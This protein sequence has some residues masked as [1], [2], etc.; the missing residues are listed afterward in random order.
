MPGQQH[1]GLGEVEKPAHRMD[2]QS[3]KDMKERIKELEKQLQEKEMMIRSLENSLHISEAKFRGMEEAVKVLGNVIV[4]MS[5]GSQPAGR[6]HSSN[7]PE[8]S[9][10][11]GQTL[12]RATMSTGMVGEG[13]QLA[14]GM[15]YIQQMNQQNPPKVHLHLPEG[16]K[17]GGIL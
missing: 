7:Q 1:S 9:L 6:S 16:W 12:T 13:Q 2:V 11:F 10:D 17:V 8:T 4:K 3:E 15:A 14:P 5:D